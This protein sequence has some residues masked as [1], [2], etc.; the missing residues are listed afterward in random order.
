MQDTWTRVDEYFAK[1]LIRADHALEQAIVDSSAAGLP[2]ISVT[3]S[4]GKL[5]SQLV[6][7]ARAKRV[8]E[9]GTLGGYSA[10]WMARALPTDGILITLEIDARH[11]AVAQRNVDRAGLTDRVSIVVAPAAES[12]SRMVRESVPPFDLIFIDADKQGSVTY[13]EFAVT[14]SHPGSLIVVDNVVRDGKVADASSTDDNVRGIQALIDVLDGDR[15]VAATV[16]QTVGGKG[17]DGL[18]LATVA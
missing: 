1:R 11:A 18:L 3:P 15:R 6:G 7:L 16:I 12:L 17:Y 13:F 14:L 4:Q 2:P 5:L 8:L 9:I 10:I